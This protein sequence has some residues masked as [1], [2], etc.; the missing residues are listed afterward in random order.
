[1]LAALIKDN[2]DGVMSRRIG[3]V[4]QLKSVTRSMSIMSDMKDP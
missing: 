2:R 4:T 3:C 1:M